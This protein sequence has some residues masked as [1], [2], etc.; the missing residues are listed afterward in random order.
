MPSSPIFDDPAV[1]SA[2]LRA[3]A[4]K[5]VVQ[6]ILSSDKVRRATIPIY[7]R[8]STRADEHDFWL[9]KLP[10]FVDWLED[11]FPNGVVRWNPDFEGGRTPHTFAIEVIFS[12]QED[13]QGAKMMVRPSELDEERYHQK[14]EQLAYRESDAVPAHTIV[15]GR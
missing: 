12:L 3:G 14:L 1:R 11:R 4:D 5:G 6:T 9:I 13:D 8:G 15:H 10:E 2:L 7:S